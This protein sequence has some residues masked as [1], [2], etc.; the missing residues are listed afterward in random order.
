MNDQNLTDRELILAVDNDP[1]ATP[2]ERELANRLHRQLVPPAPIPI[3]RHCDE[4]KED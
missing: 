2:R 4:I 1:G 3:R